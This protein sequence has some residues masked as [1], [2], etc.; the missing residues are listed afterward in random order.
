MKREEKSRKGEEDWNGGRAG[1]ERNVYWDGTTKNKCRN[2]DATPREKSGLIH[3]SRVCGHLSQ[4]AVSPAAM[5]FIAIWSVL[6]ASVGCL[7]GLEGVTEAVPINVS[8]TKRPKALPASHFTPHVSGPLDPLAQ[9]AISRCCET[10]TCE[11]WPMLPCSQSSVVAP[12]SPGSGQE[13]LNT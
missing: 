10:L 4:L 12:N 11:S 9:V 8:Q 3:G 6:H 7:Y 5:A 1:T 2:G 13:E